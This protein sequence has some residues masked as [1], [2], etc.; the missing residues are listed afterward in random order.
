MAPGYYHFNGATYY[1]AP[2]NVWYYYPGYYGGGGGQT[3]VVTSPSPYG[4]P[5]P[6]QG[7]TITTPGSVGVQSS[8]VQ[9]TVTLSGGTTISVFSGYAPVYVAGQTF[10]SPFGSLYGCPPYIRSE[11][12]RTSPYP[13]A[14]GNETQ[15]V[16]VW[17]DEDSFVSDDARR[18]AGL[19]TA[20]NDLTRFWE[21][22]DSSALRRHVD[23]D[24]SVAVFRGG[25]FLYSL[26][27]A[28]LLA[29]CEDA[30][31]RV[32]TVAFR[33]TDI[34]KRDDGL[35]NAYARHT[36][37]LPGESAVST[38]QAATVRCSLVY[39]GGGWRLSAVSFASNNQD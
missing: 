21:N 35:V 33:F 28:D 15:P 16:H 4:Y 3:V 1:C 37:R 10:P 22:G 36:Y 24:L 25:R 31:V 30:R 2:N 11:Y 23:S 7:T 34:R 27:R 19:R 38:P 32:S 9:S 8:T 17:S 20:L 6:Y 29:L 5:Y 18:A 12:V 14:R 39:V 13:Y 26:E